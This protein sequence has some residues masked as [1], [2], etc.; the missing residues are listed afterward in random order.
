MDTIKQ[1]EKLHVDGTNLRVIKKIIYREQRVAVTVENRRGACLEVKR[2]VRQ[3][4][5]FHQISLTGTVKR[6]LEDIP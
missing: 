4:V 2:G 3:D 5:S 1:L 6:E